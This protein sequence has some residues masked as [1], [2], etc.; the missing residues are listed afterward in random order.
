MLKIVTDRLFNDIFSMI[1]MYSCIY[2]LIKYRKNSF[3]IAT[4]LYSIAISAKINT[5]LFLPGIAYIYIKAKGPL[6]L[7]SQLIFIVFFQFFVGLPF[8]LHNPANYFNKSFDF[9]RNF[10]FSESLNWQMIPESIFSNRIF[11][12]TLLTLHV[13]LLLLFLLLKWEKPANLM[14]FFRKMRLNAW[15]LNAELRPLNK[16]FMIR[17]VFIC[18]L[19]GILCCRSI[20]YQF[21]VWYFST[22]PFLVW[23]TKLP[24]YLKVGMMLSFNYGWSYQRS[25]SKS[26]FLLVFHL[27][28]LF[29]LAVYDK[30]VEKSEK[31]EEKKEIIKKN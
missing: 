11:H 17:V 2:F 4:L 22:L 15:G 18:N 3:F 19:I 29:L 14:D 27:S 1:Y 28:L 21:L 25:S 12:K 6:F 24:I 31:V 30:K 26:I 7:I 20:H 5:L 23:Q 10:E 13:L 9:S 16:N 8:I